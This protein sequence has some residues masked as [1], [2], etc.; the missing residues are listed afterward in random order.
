MPIGRTGIGHS[1]GVPH[2]RLRCS[3]LGFWC[4][5]GSRPAPSMP[6]GV[7]QWNRGTLVVSAENNANPPLSDVFPAD[8][9]FP[10]RFWRVGVP[11]M[12]HAELWN[13]VF[14]LWDNTDSAIV[15]YS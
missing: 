4:S 5:T 3:T 1:T 12:A 14:R 8:F 15:P 6:F 2:P 7:F 13:T 9:G 10:G 11:A